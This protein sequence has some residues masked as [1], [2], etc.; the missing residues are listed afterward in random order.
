MNFI[1][2]TK[3]T[4]SILILL[5]N[6]LFAAAAD[7]TVNVAL[8]NWGTQVRATSQYSAEYAATNVVDGSL[9]AA[10]SWLSKDHATLPQT[11]TLALNEPFTLTQIVVNQTSW[12]GTSMYHTKN[13]RVDG[14]VDGTTF[15]TIAKG[16]LA[17]ASDAVWSQ[18][19]ASVTYRAIRIVITSSYTSVQ[20]CGLG[21]VQLMA[22]VPADKEPPYSQISTTI[23]WQTFRGMFKMSISLEPAASAWIGHS[24]PGQPSPAGTYTSGPYEIS[25]TQSAPDS[26]ARIIRWNIRRTDNQPFKVLANNIE[27]KTSYSGVYKI[28]NPNSMSQQNYGVDLPFRI[29]SIATSQNNQPVVW[30]QQ[31]D[32]KNTLIFGL[33]DQNPITGIEGSTYDWGNNGGEASG[34][35]NSYV[36]VTMNRSTP[37]VTL[38]VTSYSEAL[39]I[40]ANPEKSWF[41]ALE[42]YSAAVDNAR[43]FVARPVSDWAFNP[44]WHSW[45][46][47]ADQIDET[48]IRDDALRAKHLGATT[49]ELDAGWNIPIGQNYSFENEGDYNFSNRF[50]NAVGM[51]SDMHAAGQRAVLHVAPLL[52]GKNS[53]AWAQ[54]SD[55]MLKVKGVADPHLDPRLKKVQDYL[56]ASWENMF[57]K[58]DIDGLW[59]DFLEFPDVVDAPAAGKQVIASDVHAAYTMLMQSLYRKALALKPNAVI[60]LRRSFANLNSKTFCTHVWPMDVPQDYNMNRR[61]IVYMKTFGTG[62]LTH[63]CCTSWAVSESDL[64]VARQMA[65]MAMA[66]VPA[67]SVKLAE[68]PASHNAIIKAWLTFYEQ[69]KRELVLGRMTPLLPTPPSAAIRIESDRKAFFGFF[70]AV[71]GLIEL[72]KHVDTITIVNAYSNRTVTRLEGVT[73]DWQAQV[74]DQTWNPLNK[75]NLKADATGG[76]DINLSGPTEC[77]SIVLTKIA[78]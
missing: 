54:M 25:M 37:T 14:S 67:F 18:N 28:F 30:M 8:L 70:E 24:V 45:Y 72:T 78:H 44:M 26:I 60:I 6:I 17:D 50:P 48:L 16:T 63:A 21:E 56:L 31:T 65:S 1:P 57:A 51:I 13:F 22:S 58:Y 36:R 34:I 77:H 11:L 53:K 35:A 46:A 61:D 40:N 74:Y 64:N 76:L 75:V 27:C 55:C 23:D 59:Y 33:L 19:I 4:F 3:I 52:M 43:N 71:S 69:N 20:T 5:L 10:H 29:N 15:Q 38:T 12:N 42:G 49:I 73:G 68:S 47:H 62:V 2:Q 39:Y 41:E 9:Q 7:K 66:G 32:G